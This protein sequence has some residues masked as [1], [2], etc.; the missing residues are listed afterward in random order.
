MLIS[1]MLR[2]GGKLYEVR[3]RAGLSQADVAELAEIS[4]RAYADIE[5]GGS[6]MRADTLIRI[7]RALKITPD[8][9]FTEP[10]PIGTFD[11]DAVL[12]R[13]STCSPDER[14]TALRLLNVYLSSIGK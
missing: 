9:I 10:E 7:C 3:K 14:A 6:N 4:D 8:E 12:M 1:D 2:I 13:L 11:P 5:R